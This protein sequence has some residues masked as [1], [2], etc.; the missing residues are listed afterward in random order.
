MLPG[1]L[2]V[3]I[4]CAPVDRR[5]QKKVYEEDLLGKVKVTVTRSFPDQEPLWWG[6]GGIID[7]NMNNLHL[8]QR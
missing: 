2:L 5:C 3:I 8:E 1:P 7:E 6:D 4:L